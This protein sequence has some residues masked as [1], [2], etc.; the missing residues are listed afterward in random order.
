MWRLLFRSELAQDAFEY[1]LVV[2]V[3]VAVMLAGLLAFDG[4][5]AGFLDGA[6]CASVDTAQQGASG[7]CVN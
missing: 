5:V 1:V 6:I 7:D 2:G 4:L 3:A